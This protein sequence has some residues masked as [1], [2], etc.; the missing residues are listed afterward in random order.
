ML[1]KKSKEKERKNTP[2]P[3]TFGAPVSSVR[4]RQCYWFWR[5]NR[6]SWFQWHT[7]RST[8]SW[9]SWWKLVL[10]DDAKSTGI[11]CIQNPW[12]SAKTLQIRQGEV[13]TQSDGI[14]SGSFSLVELSRSHR[15][16]PS[17]NK[18]SRW[19]QHGETFDIL[20]TGILIVDLKHWH[21]PHRSVLIMR[22]ITMTMTMNGITTDLI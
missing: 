21:Q 8:F 1:F 10:N 7:E 18:F 20:G 9:D 15:W 13:K 14:N 22:M 17:G 2:Y 19:A 11:V 16:P 5:S 12:V 3:T 4:E 6:K